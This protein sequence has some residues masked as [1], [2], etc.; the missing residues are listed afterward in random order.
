MKR[1]LNLV[2][3]LL[4]L[5][6]E[7]DGQGALK[8][9]EDYNKKIVAYHLSLLGQAGYVVEKVQWA[10]D[11]PIWITAS[12]TWEGHEFLD[13][14]KNDNIWEKTKEGIKIK[15]LEVGSVPLEVLK[16]FATLQFKNLFGLT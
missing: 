16:E 3:E 14:I 5:I 2:R 10:G 7:N 1:D 11:E 6:E 15:G 12:L 13:S 8:L 4:L 9:P